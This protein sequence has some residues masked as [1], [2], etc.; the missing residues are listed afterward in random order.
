[1]SLHPLSFH[2]VIQGFWNSWG[3]SH[4]VHDPLLQ[5]FVA[6]PPILLQWLIW[7]LIQSDLPAYL[8]QQ[9]VLIRNK[10]LSSFLS[11]CPPLGSELSMADYQLLSRNKGHWDLT[12]SCPSKGLFSTVDSSWA[13]NLTHFYL[14]AGLLP[15]LSA[16][17][18][19]FSFLICFLSRSFLFSSLV[20]WCRE[21]FKGA[22][23]IGQVPHLITKLTSLGTLNSH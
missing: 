7:K 22:L 10:W 16:L 3:G 2:W 15:F 1:M 6:Q 8:F 14:L 20:V 9:I 4:K 11:S 17:L 18:F 13:L 19:H 21:A 5:A 12:G 23:P